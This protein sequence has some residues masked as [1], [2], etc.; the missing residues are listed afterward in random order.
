MSRYDIW[1][2][3]GAATWP[4][5]LLFFGWLAVRLDWPRLGHGLRLAGLWLFAGITTTPLSLWLMQP[6]EA[7]VRQPQQLGSVQNIV[8][9]A[10]AEQLASSLRSK[11]PEYSEA[12]ERIMAAVALQK[13]FPDATL[14]L[15]GGLKLAGGR[16][17]VSYA[18]E[19]ARALGVPAAKLLLI[20]GTY[21]TAQN[22][23]AAARHFGS[24]DTILL[25]TSAFHM[26]RSLLC[27]QKLGLNPLA[28][29]V[30]SRVPEQLTLAQKFTPHLISNFKRFDDAAHEWVGLIAYRWLGYTN[31][32][33]PTL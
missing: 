6:L 33:L 9:L 24:A 4:F 25:V 13:Q 29:P 31:A 18:G 26:P 16:V 2:V 11:R 17:D 14:V 27:F 5:W 19:T 28:Y 7:A 22:A 3:A 20:E 1:N 21:S 23:Q 12:G 32:Y 10:G 30:D 15:V 8:M